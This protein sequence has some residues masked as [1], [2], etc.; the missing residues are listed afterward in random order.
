MSEHAPKPPTRPPGR[1]RV[2]ERGAVISAYVP[3][4]QADEIIELARM[5]DQSVSAVVRDLLRRQLP[6]RETGQR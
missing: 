3:A 4:R 6:S 2:A 1:P 5:R